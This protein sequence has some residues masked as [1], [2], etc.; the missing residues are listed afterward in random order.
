MPPSS[1]YIEDQLDYSTL[2]QDYLDDYDYDD[3]LYYPEVP[4]SAANLGPAKKVKQ[5]KKGGLKHKS[6]SKDDEAEEDEVSPC[7]LLNLPNDVLHVLLVRLPPICLLQLGAT[8]KLLR[9]ELKSESVW[10]QCYINRFLWD[11]A[12]GN[13]RAR[14]EVKALVQGCSGVGGRGWKKEALSREAM[15]ER[16]LVSRSSNVIHHPF[17]VLINKMSLSYPPLLPHA[18]APMVVGKMSNSGSN[19]PAGSSAKISH[20]QRYEA[21]KAVSTRPSPVLYCASQEHAAVIK[22]DPLTG[23]V[24]KG[25]WGPTEEANFHIR[26]QWDPGLASAIFLPRRS[27]NHILWG[28]LSGSCVHTTVQA[29]AHA[30]YGGR[31]TSVNVMS[32]PNDMHEGAVLS[33][34]QPES[35]GKDPMK[36]VT[37][38]QDGRL[39]YWQLNPGSTKSG[40]LTP[41]EG[42]PASITCLFSSEPV[43]KPFKERSEE[44]RLRQMASPD[45]IYLSACDVQHDVVCGVTCDGDLRLW[46]DAATN[47]TEVRLDVG[48]EADYGGVTELNLVTSRCANG[49]SASVLIHHLRH[50]NFAR[51][52]ISLDGESHKVK[53]T[54]FSSDGEAPLTTLRAFLLP[55]SPIS[56]PPEAQYT[57]SARIITPTDSGVASPAAPDVDVENVENVENV[58]KVAAAAEQFGRVV[59]GGDSNGRVYIWEWDGRSVGDIIKPIRDWAVGDGKITCVEMSCGLV[60]V[61]AFNGQVWVYDP[62]PPEPTRLRK[63]GSPAHLTPGDLI[64]AGSDEHRAKFFNVNHLILENDLII[65]GIGRNVLAWRAGTGKGRQSGKNANVN[66]RGGPTGGRS[67]FRGPSRTLDLRDLHQDAVDSHYEIRAENEATRAHTSHEDQHLAAMNDLGLADG[68]EALRYAILLS[69]QEADASA[70]ASRLSAASPAERRRADPGMGVGVPDASLEEGTGVSDDEAAAIEAVAEFERAEA[71]RK[72]ARAQEDEEDLADVLEQIRLAEMR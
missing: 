24:S 40:K 20:R 46:F 28:L 3:D 17:P 34:Y 8:C 48:S 35:Q 47:P 18:K 65:A 10:R 60:A 2:D 1:L 54:F 25:V 14:E 11:G 66:R 55:S 23:K 30:K 68:D 19:S 62:L 5:P 15:L 7:H 58:R 43:E 63:L 53:T 44:V 26:P 64:V 16:W 50:P 59:V 57:L 39:K 13:G 9:D 27:H 61:G 6:K 12:A 67:E 32:L 36:W 72:A 70:A 69:Q 4:S 49:V 37:G 41:S 51:H 52:D 42:V 56:Q 21:M 29:R 71:A 33:I 38:G 31:P 45:G 22:S